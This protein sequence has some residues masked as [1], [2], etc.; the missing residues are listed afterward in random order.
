MS[1]TS[2][3]KRFSKQTAVWWTNPV[4]DGYGGVTYDD[5][6]EIKC[7][8]DEYVKIINNT[9]GEEEI[10]NAQVLTNED[11]EEGDLLYLGNLADLED[12]AEDL[13]ITL[14]SDQF[15]IYPKQVEIGVHKVVTREKISMPRSLTQFVKLVYLRPNWET[16]L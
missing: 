9:K 4:P 10:S 13:D 3:V 11:L 1:I 5:P 16:K 6:V 15:Y 8:W 7:R 12:L 2:V 14:E